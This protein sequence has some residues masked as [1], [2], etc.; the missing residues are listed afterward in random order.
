MTRS[1]LREYITGGL[2]GAGTFQLGESTV[3]WRPGQGL[4]EFRAAV[5][6]AGANLHWEDIRTWTEEQNSAMS[7]LAALLWFE[8]HTPQPGSTLGP[9]EWVPLQD[10]GRQSGLLRTIMAVRGELATGPTLGDALGWALKTFF[11]GPH[12]VIAY[13]KLPESTFRFCWE[14]GRLRFYPAGHDRFSRRVR[15]ATLSPRSVR[16]LGFGD[17]SATMRRRD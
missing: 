12:E 11:L 16:T 10:S 7:R 3:A 15:G 8:A 14:E 17:A 9:W 13:S 4:S 1:E 6:A 5:L 2:V